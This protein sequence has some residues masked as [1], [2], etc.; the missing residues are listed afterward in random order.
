[1]EIKSKD[2]EIGGAFGTNVI[3]EKRMDNFV[4]NSCR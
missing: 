3:D 1:M 2:E 4:S